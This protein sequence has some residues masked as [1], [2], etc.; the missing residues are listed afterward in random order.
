MHD[1]GGDRQRTVEA[2]DLILS[3]LTEA[4]YRFVTVAELFELS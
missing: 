2:T 3:Q 4:G 1:G